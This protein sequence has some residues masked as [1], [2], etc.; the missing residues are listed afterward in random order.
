MQMWITRSLAAE[1]L[2]QPELEL[3]ALVNA[4]I[5]ATRLSEKGTVELASGEVVRV[6]KATGGYARLG[7][8]CEPIAQERCAQAAAALYI[9]EVLNTKF[10][11][12]W[13]GTQGKAQEVMSN[14]VYKLADMANGPEILQRLKLFLP[15]VADAVRTSIDISL[16]RH[17]LFAN[18]DPAT[19]GALLSEALGQMDRQREAAAPYRFRP[20]CWYAFA[21]AKLGDA[22]R[23]DAELQ[24]CLKDAQAAGEAAAQELAQAT[25]GMIKLM[26]QD[27]SAEIPI[28]Y[29]TKITGRDSA[30]S[31]SSVAQ[32]YAAHERYADAIRQM[33][34]AAEMLRKEGNRKELAAAEG[35]LGF[36]YQRATPQDFLSAFS[37]YEKAIALDR[38]LGD[39]KAE[40]QVQMGRAMAF[41][42]QRR[43]EEARQ[44]LETADKLGEQIGALDIRAG[45]AWAQAELAQEENATD[46]EA[47][48]LHA[49]EL[50]ASA[51]LLEQEAQMLERAGTYAFLAGKPDDGIERLLRARDLVDKTNNAALKSMVSRQLGYAY[52]RA[53]RFQD[54]LGSMLAAKRLAA[55]ANDVTLEAN[56][57]LG[58]AGAYQVLGEWGACLHASSE[59]LDKFSATGNK[60][61]QLWA[62]GYLMSVYS[63][64][65]SEMKDFSKAADI[66]LQASKLT[67]VKPDE[68]LQMN[69]L[70]MYVQT[71]AYDLAVDVTQK[72]EAYCLENKDE[73]CS[74]YVHLYLAEIDGKRGLYKEARTELEKA[75]PLV[76]KVGDFYLQG[77]FHY[78]T[79][80]LARMMG[81]Y[82]EAVAA[83]VQVIETYRGLEEGSSYGARSA[84]SE[85]YS[86][87]FDELVDTL[88]LS[89][90]KDPQRLSVLGATALRY[91][92]ANRAEEFSRRWGGNVAQ[93]LSRRLPPEV[94]EREA[95]LRL[96]KER[97]ATGLREPGSGGQG[98][99]AE[100]IEAELKSADESLRNFV[101]EL[102]RAQPLYAAARY[103]DFLNI[104]QLPL[105]KGEVLAEMRVTEDATFVWFLDA[106][107]GS[108]TVSDFYRVEHGRAW[109]RS[110]VREIKAA[111]ADGRVPVGELTSSQDLARALF[112]DSA[113]TEVLKSKAV[114]YVPDD[115]LALIPLEVLSPSATAGRFP[116]AGIPSTYYPS[117]EAFRLSRIARPG[118]TWRAAFLGV[119]DPITSDKDKR[120]I[121][122]QTA[123]AGAAIS[124]GDA[125]G[126][127]VMQALRSGGLS[128]E[129]L[130]GTGDE[131]NGIAKMLLESGQTAEARVGSDAN[132]PKLLHTDLS[133]YRFV[134]F[135]THGLLPVESGLKEPA[136]LFSFA[137]SP[138]EMLL[139]ASEVLDLN[140]SADM[141]VL[142]ACN[143]GTG[144]VSKAEGVYNLGRAFMTAGAGSVVM[145]LWEVADESTATLMQELYAGILKGEPKNVALAHARAALM[146][147]GFG[148]PFYWAPFILMG[149]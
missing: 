113:L 29:L 106:A 50:S 80:L 128:L 15:P 65:S 149:E 97:L 123:A 111:L 46:V 70:E 79:A 143:T 71:G 19:A 18:E 33:T 103:P 144:E 56:A 74:A 38:D 39:R 100:Q 51:Q 86:F 67:G 68:S 17:Y 120:W 5:L 45:A 107:N 85:N 14:A 147:R 2:Q 3:L 21:V 131:I 132:K 40:A 146:R 112:P 55:I 101:A 11:E 22:A 116:L 66:Y 9:L 145:S 88:Y 28:E 12:E 54:G 57:D 36:Y 139:P 91:S 102:R 42:A 87:V 73:M 115:A 59:A 25:S 47:R 24:T 20:Q 105:R 148:H 110:K 64:R 27:P 138:S 35:L 13:G 37:H 1:H 104:E 44:C 58:L 108:T 130:P 98:R 26:R 93:S 72:A 94:R 96:A 129:R 16:G 52:G 122:A 23:A 31:H 10:R 63:E 95:T 48:Y 121:A 84:L 76:K 133:A 99:S 34:L 126:Q 125:G 41:S 90:R 118:Q 6:M 117:A 60:E 89:A 140:L 49:A 62:Y 119:G 32:A 127:N 82:D 134:H 4:S 141:V 83:Y 92:D 136:L 53:G 75:R 137:P 135:A 114:I 30:E 7:Q 142:S 77:V 61:G 81:N 43:F 69:L 124:G 78:K 109:V 8:V